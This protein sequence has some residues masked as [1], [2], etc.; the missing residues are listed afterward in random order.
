MMDEETGSNDYSGSHEE[1][2]D[3]RAA[4]KR[5]LAQLA[6]EKIARKHQ[7]KGYADVHDKQ[8]RKPKPYGEE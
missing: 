6:S 1:H 2:L 4:V 3:N 7:Q 8:A 5:H